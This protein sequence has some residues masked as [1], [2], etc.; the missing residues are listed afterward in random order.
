MKRSV[1]TSS[2]MYRAHRLTKSM[3]QDDSSL[4]YRTQ[5]GINIRH[6]LNVEKTHR[7]FK[8]LQN[9]AYKW[10]KKRINHDNNIH[11]EELQDLLFDIN[12]DLNIK[13]FSLY[14]AMNAWSFSKELVNRYPEN[15]KIYA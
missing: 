13:R 7:E 1:I 11:S 3:C 5:L 9:K 15:I 10:I 14:E 8:L 12:F 6:Y 2:I 4:D